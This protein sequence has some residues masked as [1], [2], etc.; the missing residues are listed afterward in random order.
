MRKHLF[1]FCLFIGALTQAQVQQE[2]FESFKLQER[3][4]VSYYF[5][6]GYDEDKR[7]PLIMV[8]DADR[9]FDQVLATS[10]Y[11]SRFH[12]APEAIIVGIHQEKDDLRYEDCAF[13]EDNGLPSEKG[14]KF[15]EFV[16][17][18]LMPFLGTKYSIAPFKIMVGYGITANFGNFYL[19]KERSLFDAYISISPELAPEME[20]RVAS[21]L[22]AFDKTIFYH[23]MVEGEK[24]KNRNRILEMDKNIKEIDKEN[25]HYTFDEFPNTDKIA[26]PSYG[27][28][29]AFDNIFQIFKPITPKEYKEKMLTSEE[30]VY[31][32]LENKYQMIE[33]LFGFRKPVDLNDIMAVYAACKKKEDVESLKP[34]SDLCKKQF[35]ETMMGYYFEGEYLELMGEPKKAMRTFEKAF[36]LDEI[37]FLTKDMALDKIDAIKADFGY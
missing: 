35:P 5:P 8:L 18:E 3:R 31:Q 4:D 13:E 17:M 28:G 6:E 29:K 12:G 22:A 15:F 30:P 33:D 36:A 32:Y 7:Y 25:I 19:F 10:K 20:T 23:L 26:V 27:I 34:L 16:G 24:S 11:Y 9:L 37:D 14:K 21:R 2:I 1:L